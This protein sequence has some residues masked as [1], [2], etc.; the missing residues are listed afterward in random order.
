M[1]VDMFGGVRRG[2]ESLRV[3]V[4]RDPSVKNRLSFD[5]RVVSRVTGL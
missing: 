3:V 5:V 4:E 1:V 2:N